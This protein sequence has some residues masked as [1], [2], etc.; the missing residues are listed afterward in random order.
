MLVTI[1]PSVFKKKDKK[2]NNIYRLNSSDIFK[3]PLKKKP[4]FYTKIRLKYKRFEEKNI[5]ICIKLTY[6]TGT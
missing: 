5:R 4:T 6:K 3:F 2:V 1:Y